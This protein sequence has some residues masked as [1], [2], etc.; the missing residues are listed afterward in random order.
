MG[1]PLLFHHH[2]G[3]W[4]TSLRQVLADA[5]RGAA[6]SLLESDAGN[7][8]GPKVTLH[9]TLLWAWSYRWSRQQKPAAKRTQRRRQ[10]ETPR[11]WEPVSQSSASST[12][13]SAGAALSA[14]S[15]PGSRDWTSSH[16][17][18]S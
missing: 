6:L 18:Q 14:R 17:P 7:F 12:S 10:R 2:K 16:P 11:A 13:P 3:A 9:L 8:A 5:A 4:G 15:D 1:E